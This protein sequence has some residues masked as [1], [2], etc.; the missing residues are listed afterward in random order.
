MTANPS[1]RELCTDMVL[2]MEH[3][4]WAQDSLF[5]CAKSLVEWFGNTKSLRLHEAFSGEQMARTR[6]LL[7]SA[8]RSMRRLE[9]LAFTARRTRLTLHR[10]YDF[11]LQ[12]LMIHRFPNLKQLHLAGLTKGGSDSFDLPSLNR[13]QTMVKYF[14]GKGPV[15]EL[16][17]R[18][19]Y[20]RRHAFA[21]L[22]GWPARLEKFT[23]LGQSRFG[24]SS[25]D[26]R[27]VWSGLVRHMPSPQSIRIGSIANQMPRSAM[28]GML[29]GIEFTLFESLTFLSLSYW[30]TG[31]DSGE[32]S[33]LAPRLETFEWS[34]DAE[35]NRL[36]HL[37]HFQQAE[38]DFMRRLAHAAAERKI[39][40]RRIDIVF[41]PAPVVG[42]MKDAGA[43]FLGITEASLE[44]P[45]DRMNRLAEELRSFGI[46]LTYN[47]PSVI[48]EE[49]EV[50][51]LKACRQLGLS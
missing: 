29:A 11:E 43:E 38:E 9:R 51:V 33:L 15:M 7:S 12:K 27:T 40:L 31:S 46:Q 4:G 37:D 3:P 10:V 24:Y 36:L 17:I 14:R 8:S 44:Y 25:L 35:D 22:V 28:S 32:V 45:W 16:S 5:G 39:P 19:Y 34:F 6:T 20:E 1:L 21:Q 18:D 49:Y 42:L 30:T 13:K 50:A 2:D 47:K 41:T 48:R 26:L 23:C